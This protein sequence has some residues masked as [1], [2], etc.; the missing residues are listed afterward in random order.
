MAENDV[1]S[2]KLSFFAGCFLLL[3]KKLTKHLRVCLLYIP[4]ILAIE[5][6]MYINHIFNT[7]IRQLYNKLNIRYLTC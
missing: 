4:I 7:A 5:V 2:K 3:K 6:V 1:I